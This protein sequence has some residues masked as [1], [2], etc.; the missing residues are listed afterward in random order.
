[1]IEVGTLAFLK[2][3]VVDEAN[4]A[5]GASQV[6]CL[7]LGW[8]KPVSV[9]PL[10]HLLALL[11]SLDIFFQSR[12]DLSTEGAVMLF[13][14]RFHLFQERTRKADGKGFDGFLFGVHT[15]LLQQKWMH[16]KG[17]PLAPLHQGMPLS[18]PGLKATGPSA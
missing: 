10:L 11:I 1:M 7:R 6:V 17:F 18:S 15:S 12:Q 16:V 9:G 13:G 14:Y 8:V 4:T 5:E 2:G 3:V